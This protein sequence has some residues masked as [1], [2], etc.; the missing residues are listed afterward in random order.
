MNAS[1]N[2]LDPVPSSR[3]QIFTA[4][5]HRVMFFFGVLQ[6]VLTIG[7]WAFDLLGRYLGWLAPVAW[8]VPPA[9]AHA[10]LMLYCLFPFFIFGF[11][12]TAMPNWL[13]DARV[14]R[15]EYLFAAGMLAAGCALVYVGLLAGRAVI[16]V[17]VALHVAGWVVGLAALIRLVVTSKNSNRIFP[18]L[19]LVELALG[20]LGSF[21]FLLWLLGATAVFAEIARRAGVWFF[22]LPVFFTVSHRMVPFFS[23]RVLKDYVIFRPKWSLPFMLVAS[24]AHGLLEVGGAYSW[25]WVVDFPLFLWVGYLAF[26]WGL[27]QSFRARLLAV[28]H[29][30]LVGLAGALLL[31]TVQSAALALGYP[32]ILGTAPLHAMTISYFSAIALGMVSRVSLG[33]SGQA[34]QADT[35]TWVCFLGVLTT[36]GLRVAAELPGM[37]GELGP[38]LTVLAA[39]IWL[40]CFVPWASRYLPIYLKP[41]ADGGAG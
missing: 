39:L 4:A 25:L 1:I 23:S 31:Y 20:G 28:L 24:A 13:G 32:G 30:S 15:L 41:R 38:K 11:L 6:T 5:P 3:W 29:I 34:L 9:W 36:A 40:A 17:G 22:L 16:A 18:A 19:F 21:A 14:H 35:L 10:Y 12:M 27:T 26:K 37:P 7:W 33:H 2:L 8:A